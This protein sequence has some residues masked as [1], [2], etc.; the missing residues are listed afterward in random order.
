MILRCCTVRLAAPAN[1][2]ANSPVRSVAANISATLRTWA[3]SLGGPSSV[4]IC[5]LHHDGQTSAK[6]MLVPSFRPSPVSNGQMP[7]RSAQRGSSR[8]SRTTGI[9]VNVWLP[10][11]PV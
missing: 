3:L 11:E 2:A 8:N 6:T 1:H 7:A 4:R 9:P 10:T 5:F